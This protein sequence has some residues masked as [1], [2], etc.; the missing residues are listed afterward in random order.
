VQRQVGIQF[1]TALGFDFAH[2]RIDTSFHPFCGGYPDDTRI[3][4]RYDEADFTSALMGVIH[5]TGHALYE[6]GL[7]GGRWRHQPVGRARGM[8]MHESQSLLME[9][10]ACRSREFTQWAA[11]RL[12]QAFGGSGPEWDAENLYQL[13]IRVERGF[14]RVDADEVTYP[15]HVIIRYR[16]EKALV[17]GSMEVEDLP[18]AWNEGYTRLLGITPPDDRLGCLQDIHWYGGSWGYFPTYTLGAM[19]AAQLF[20]AARRADPNIM[21]AIGGGDFG[22]LRT[23]L[24]ANVHGLGSSLSTRELL[25][26]A[27]GRAL[28]AEVFKTHLKE[29]YLG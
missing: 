27:T 22:P 10:Q 18:A 21:P 5:E 13:G 24:R 16:L 19:T 25:V 4:T 8:Q 9:M 29:R 2:G 15:A 23:W 20:D 7:P 14:I 1:M 28:D 17:E 11:P 26:R 12:A 3:T 6:F